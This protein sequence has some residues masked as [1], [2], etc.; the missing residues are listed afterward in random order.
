MAGL[1]LAARKKRL[2]IKERADLFTLPQNFTG[3]EEKT[4]FLLTSQNDLSLRRTAGLQAE[5][6]PEA[7]RPKVIT[8]SATGPRMSRAR[9]KKCVVRRAIRP[10]LD[11]RVPA[12]LVRGHLRA[13]A[14]RVGTHAGVYRV[15]LCAGACLPAQ[16]TAG[17]LVQGSMSVTQ[18]GVCVWACVCV[19]RGADP[20]EAVQRGRWRR[21]AAPPKKES[22]TTP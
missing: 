19:G 6:A 2:G 7:K 15:K 10:H 22:P 4:F 8:V 3:H 13:R 17:A 5:K 9:T 20:P 1:T 18:A 11:T 12:C 14:G 16:V 21:L